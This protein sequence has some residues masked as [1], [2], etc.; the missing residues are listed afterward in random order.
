[1]AI[2]AVSKLIQKLHGLI[3]GSETLNH[4]KLEAGSTCYA[5]SISVREKSSPLN[6]S[7]AFR[8]FAVA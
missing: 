7:A 3:Q 5:T 6:S 1:M 2:P 8:C 4:A